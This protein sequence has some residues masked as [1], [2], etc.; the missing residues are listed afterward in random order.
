[1]QY[2]SKFLLMVGDNLL[3]HL[4]GDYR[5]MLSMIRE[6]WVLGV[7]NQVLLWRTEPWDLEVEGLRFP[8]LP[9]LPV[10]YL[11]RACPPTV[12]D[13]KWLVSFYRLPWLLLALLLF[14]HFALHSLVPSL[15]VTDIFRPFVGYKEVR[16]VSKE[17]RHVSLYKCMVNIKHIYVFTD[18]N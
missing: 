2:F 10:H 3:D 5:V 11:S 13:G 15:V 9:M 4:V 1:M 18:I 12:H 17:S 8:F 6:L 14:L 16:L 7:W